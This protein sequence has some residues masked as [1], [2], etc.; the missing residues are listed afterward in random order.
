M[1]ACQWHVCSRNTKEASVGGGGG[2]N[3]AGI[4]K[5]QDVEMEE[6]GVCRVF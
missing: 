5:L 4:R 6:Y 1:A 2:E 3:E